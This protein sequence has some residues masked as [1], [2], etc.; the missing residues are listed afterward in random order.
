MLAEFLGMSVQVTLK[1]PS[2]TG[3]SRELQEGRLLEVSPQF[4]ILSGR[5]PK[6]RIV[7]GT[8]RVLEFQG[9]IPATLVFLVRNGQVLLARKTRKVGKGRLTGYGGKIR[10]DETPEDA[11]RRELH[12]EA[13]VT[14]GLR[15]RP[16]GIVRL[17]NRG[18]EHHIHLFT[19]HEW[20]GK[21]RASKEMGK[22]MWF[23]QFDL[24]L[25]QMMRAD[26]H[27]LPYILA[28]LPVEAKA[29]Y[30]PKDQLIGPVTVKRIV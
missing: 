13:G 12:E 19:L 28:G 3:G 20:E 26:A 1:A 30:G 18:L 10:S 24:P 11:A 4:C 5:T 15:L 22:P 14:A 2:G 6:S 29:A 21:P 9:V 7:F 25:H 17:D 23:P 16:M 8:S 27:W